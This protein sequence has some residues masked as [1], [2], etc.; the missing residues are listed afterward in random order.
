MDGQVSMSWTEIAASAYRAFVASIE[1]PSPTS[2]WEQLAPQ[3]QIAWEAAVRQAADCFNNGESAT[4][5]EQDWVGWL[6]GD[7][8]T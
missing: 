3:C 1:G 8:E 5:R 4:A 7:E 2:A 6:P